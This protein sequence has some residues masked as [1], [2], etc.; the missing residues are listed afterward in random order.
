MLVG[1]FV[2]RGRAAE[3]LTFS[4]TATGSTR[5]IQSWGYDT[6]WPSY[7]NARL[8]ILT[9]GGASRVDV[10]RV[11]FHE[12]EAL[13]ADGSLGPQSKAALDAA[14][15]L[16]KMAGNKPISLT[17]DTGAGT[18]AWYLDGAG[19]VNASR[20]AAMII[21]TARYLADRHGL[22]VGTV[23]VWNEPDYWPGQPTASQ[24]SQITSLIKSEPL[25]QGVD[26]MGPSTLSPNT[27][28]YDQIAGSVNVGATH[29]LGGSATNYIDFIQRVHS[30]GDAFANPE[31]HSLAEVILGAEYGTSEVI[32]WGPALNSRGQFVQASDGVRLGYAENRGD[33]TAAAVYRSPDGKLQAFAGSFER[34]GTP[35]AYR[36]VSADREVYFNGV[37]PIRE[38]M[39][40]A[41]RDVQGAFAD[42]TYGSDAIGQGTSLDGNRWT[43][44][45]RATGQVLQV[46]NGS[47]VNG[48]AVNA[49]TDTGTLAQRWNI[50]RS[51]QGYF[52][53]LNANSGI[54][55]DMANSSLA[56]GGVAQQ[57]GNGDAL[58]QT[59]TIDPAGNGFFAIRNGNS[60][61]YLTGN[62]TRAYQTSYD[63]S[64]L[65]QWQFVLANPAATG[66]LV[67]RYDFQGN[68]NDS[69][70]GHHATLSGAPTYVAGPTAAEGLGLSFNGS[71]TYAT[72]PAGVADSTDI[73]LSTWVKWNGGGAWQ[74]IFDFGDDTTTNMYLTPTSGDGT[75]R[76]A[77]TTSGAAGEEILDT[78]PLPT[79]QWTHL[80]VTLSGNTGVLYVDGAPRVAGRILLDT[81][82]LTPTR[83]F[84]GRSQYAD[85]L[86][87]GVLDDFRIYDYALSQA[88]V[89]NLVPVSRSTWT[90]N[91]NGVWSTT[92][93]ASP[94]NWKLT[95]NASGSDYVDND[96]IVFDDTAARF[97][98]STDAD[99]RPQVATFH[100]ATTYTLSGSAGI[101]GTGRLVKNGL[102][103]LIIANRNTYSGST[104]INSG[105][106]NLT[107][108]L[109]GTPITVDAATFVESATGVISGGA[110]LVTYGLTRL[111]GSNALGQLRASG[112]GTVTI[113]GGTTTLASAAIGDA[114][115]DRVTLA[116]TGGTVTCAGELWVSSNT[117]ASGTLRLSGGTLSV[118]SWLAV[119]RGGDAGVLEMT[120]GRIN[121]TASPLTI[122]SFA[123][124]AG[125]VT[126]SGGSVVSAN[127]I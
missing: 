83:N 39:I 62:A 88:E 34:S 5:S 31:A 80:A 76:F 52:T 35:T 92:T 29:K 81:S 70:G 21:A 102:G 77:I 93:Q 66:S 6:A 122:A 16:A 72:L 106:V 85:P 112:P 49:A 43:I 38:C 7:E 37:G 20:Y 99:V 69:V 94:K 71:S 26:M 118:G 107:G 59:W 50:T 110:S 63:G 117:S 84:L 33:E 100:N 74:R 124:N 28:W 3:T 91:V 79:G 53:I 126:V 15:S 87:N 48:G 54:A 101:A 51:D 8:S 40:S 17:P 67:A 12:F 113:E 116:I 114:S 119:G 103:T 86:F 115:G 22:S 61:K 45:N 57:W 68:A 14:A 98:V 127:N 64:A 95:F 75:M 11:N 104:S 23:E 13:Q 42:I 90:G 47:V 123:G 41:T 25:L 121:L 78:S 19:G 58:P 10:V 24:V 18:D 46:A 55:L 111:A 109:A 120:G 2:L 56:D 36:M 108:S 27:W 65:Q 4:P 30:T 125:R 9:F 32:W 105:V 82:D 1:P 89:A 60:G 96:T 73:T 44:V 97:T